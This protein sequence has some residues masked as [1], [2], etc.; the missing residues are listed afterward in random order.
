M[1]PKQPHAVLYPQ[2]EV[3]LDYNKF[4]IVVVNA[5]QK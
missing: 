5:I 2:I 1:S 3:D 4:V